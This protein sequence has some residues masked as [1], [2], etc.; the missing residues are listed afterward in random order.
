AMENK[1]LNIFNSKYV[2][3]D[4][5]TATDMDFS[6]IQ[7]VIA[8]EYFHNWTGN[9]ITLKNWFQLSLKEGLTVF[10]DQEFSSDLNS[11]GV[12][13]ILDVKAL[14]ANQFPEDDGPMVH[15]VRP[16]SYIE[17]NNFY[18]MTVYEKGAEIIRMIYTILGREHFKNGMNLYFEM[19]D[20]CAVTIEDF[21]YALGKGTGTDLSGMMRW[22]TQSGT[23]VV[24]VTRHWD[25]T[26]GTLR[27]TFDQHTPVDRNQSVKKPFPVPIVYGLLDR[28][29]NE[30]PGYGSEFFLLTSTTDTVE[31]KGVDPDCIPS[32]FRN[33]SAPV[34][35][36]TDLSEKEL[37]VLLAGDSDLFNR[38]NAATKLYFKEFARIVHAIK[39][40]REPQVSMFLIDALEKLMQDRQAQKMFVAE[41]L[42]L[43]GE[44]EIGEQFE[45]IDVQAVHNARKFLRKAIAVR[46]EAALMELIDWCAD[47][48]PESLDF[49]EMSKRRLRNTALGYIGALETDDAAHRI[50]QRFQSARNMT[51]EI[52]MLHILVDIDHEARDKALNRFYDKWNHD[53][54]VLDKWFTAQ[55]V[56]SITSPEAVELLSRHPDFSFKN[57]NRVRALSGAFAMQNPVNFHREDGRGYELITNHIMALDRLNPQ[58]AARLASAFN[59]R[60]KYDDRRNALMKKELEKISR[61]DKISKNLYEVVS[62]S[63]E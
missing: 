6:N 58:I 26:D 33:F 43:P 3:A 9:R 22:Y 49:E 11:R 56:S 21:L 31:F 4:H 40:N 28:N 27:L 14:R 24:A 63:L 37:S 7:T 59:R 62:R 2:L 25:K 16:E 48:D 18:T 10:R 23:P 42:T 1:G 45:T 32:V 38:W 30:V 53:P 29:G 20:G 15:P 54:L 50:Y 44:N 17:M 13:R 60:K 57:P 52:A 39:N 61:A 46:F 12:K 34:K 8:H 35:V 19:F 47:S 36:R 55:A 51:D 41:T 5:T